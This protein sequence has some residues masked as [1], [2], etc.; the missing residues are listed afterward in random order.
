MLFLSGQPGPEAVW[1]QN[2]GDDSQTVPGV[3]ERSSKKNSRE[4]NW[5]ISQPVHIEADRMLSDQQEDAV[6]FTGNV[7]AVQGDLAINSRKMTVYYKNNGEG[8]NSQPEKMGGQGQQINK[9]IASG[10]VKVSRG[11]LTAAGDKV[12]FA[13]RDEKIF[14]TGNAKVWHQD[15]LVQ[16]EKVVFDLQEGTTVF[17]SGDQKD[18]RVKAVFYSEE[19]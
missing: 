17:E 8:N 2:K 13:L 6:F 1:A 7:V 11:N 5:R 15:N 14:I 9:I 10:E 3:K 12:I 4:D 18:K 16:G 19:D